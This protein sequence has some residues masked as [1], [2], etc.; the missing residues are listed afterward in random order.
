MPVTQLKIIVDANPAALGDIRRL[1]TCVGEAFACPVDVDV[2]QL[3]ITELGANAMQ[4][5]SSTV[6]V[7]ITRLHGPSLRIAVRDDG[8]GWP[9]LKTPEPLDLDGGRG[10]MILDALADVWG[11]ET[12]EDSGVTVWFE[13]SPAA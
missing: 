13:M 9:E 5:H 1:V 11:S 3:L 12:D 2:L 6:S 8:G 7:D 10:L 4:A